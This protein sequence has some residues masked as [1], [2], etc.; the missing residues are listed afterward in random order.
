MP[1]ALW[2]GAISFGLVN[3]P[4]RMYSAVSPHDLHFHYVH[5][6]DKSRIGY[7][8]IC[9]K[10]G[11][12]VP[13]DEIVKAFE[14]KKDEY[15]FMA[16]EDFEAA[17]TDGYKTIEIRDF[18]PYD[19]ID[20]IYFDKTFYLGPDQGGEKVYALLRE[21]MES[22]GLAAIAKYVFH[23]RQYLGCLRVR[24]RVITLVRMHFA[25]EIRPHDEIAPD[26][27][28]KPDKNELKMA[29]QLIDSFAGKFDPK[30]YDDTYR[31]T[32]CEII[33]A[34]RKGKEVHVDEVEEPEETPD[35]LAALRASLES[36]QGRG[37]KRT[38]GRNGRGG[39]K[40]GAKRNGGAA[41]GKLSR[42]ELYARAQRA[43]IPGRSDM[44]K[45]QLIKALESDS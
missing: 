41:L 42:E 37:T 14:F 39:K 6:K 30:R 35:I 33:K 17:Q 4:V 26:G 5:E 19:D 44:S 32:L 36:A 22:S 2:S 7:E 27:R 23:D 43:D 31:D 3:V 16:D 38:A 18:V 8:K 12:P 24:E 21:A 28:T 40:N 25:D 34:K 13:D 10:E 20:P 15:V 9:K 45:Q 29:E 11:K 1:R